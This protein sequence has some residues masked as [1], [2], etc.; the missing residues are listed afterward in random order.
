MAVIAPRDSH[1]LQVDGANNG[2][3]IVAVDG[4]EYHSLASSADG[5]LFSW[6]AGTVARA[7]SKRLCRHWW[8]QVVADPSGLA[9]HVILKFPV[10]FRTFPLE[11]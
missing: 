8:Y 2:H 4:G 10:K 6:G 1:L 9:T 11:K 3:D 7:T 5:K